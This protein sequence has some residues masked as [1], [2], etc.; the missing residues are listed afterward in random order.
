MTTL[1]TFTWNFVAKDI[2]LHAQ[3]QEKLRQK[4]SKLE[5]H[6]QHFPPGAVHLQIHLQKHSK[7]PAFSVALTLRVPSNIL[8]SENRATDPIPA[9]DQALKVL[10][11]E[12]ANLK[13]KLR[14]EAHWKRHARRAKLHAAKATRFAAEPMPS[15]TGPQTLADSASALLREHHG[16][17]AAYVRRQLWRDEIAGEIPKG[18]IDVLAVVDEVAQ[19]VLASPEA[20]PTGTSYLL[21]LFTLARRELRARVKR[22]HQQQSQ[23]VSLEE[24]SILPEEADRAEGYEPEQP[25]NILEEKLEPPV[26]E[27][28]DL[29]PDSSA[30]PP[31]EQAAQHDLIDYLQKVSTQWPKVERDVFALHFLEGFDADEIA[32]IE[33]LTPGEIRPL[34]KAIQDRLRE[35]TADAAAIEGRG[36]E[37]VRLATPRQRMTTPASVM[38]GERGS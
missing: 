5:R 8:R 30:V 37:P 15:G 25:L 31:D 1:S 38:K 34:I 4:L 14:R 33:G 24:S 27:T 2:R 7:K 21:W 35:L 36:C 23:T 9:L 10:L 17:L 20:K 26:V 16:R 18:A 29:L 19:R 12:L 13:S 28:R 6:L 11:R 3:L 22:L 32:M